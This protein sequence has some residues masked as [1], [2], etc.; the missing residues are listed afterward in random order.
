MSCGSL[1]D[2]VSNDLDLPQIIVS[3]FELVHQEVAS[4]WMVLVALVADTL[5]NYADGCDYP[6]AASS[7]GSVQDTVSLCRSLQVTTDGSGS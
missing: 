6:H 5:M 7:C 2:D 1:H 3:L 4:V